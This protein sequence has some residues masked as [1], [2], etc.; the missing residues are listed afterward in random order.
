MA[1]VIQF[2]ELSERRSHEEPDDL[3][4]LLKRAVVLRRQVNESNGFIQISGLKKLK[5]YFESKISDILIRRDYIDTGYFL[6]GSYVSS[7]LTS[8]SNK[9]PDSWFAIDYII[10]SNETNSPQLLKQG[11]NICFLI[12]SVFRER[13]ELR[14][15]RYE[16]YEKMGIGLFSRFYS[17]T[18]AEIGYHMSRQYKIMVN[19]TDECM[20]TI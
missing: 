19:V 20:R 8:I 15:M 12:C 4:T 2:S 16:D 18:G 7:L 10:E 1:K 11:A 14:A 13:S 3:S 5:H 6:C 17:Q 9:V